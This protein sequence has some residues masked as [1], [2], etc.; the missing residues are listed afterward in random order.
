[1]YSE[2]PK[3][4]AKA[5][6]HLENLF[7]AVKQDK[8]RADECRELLKN[9]EYEGTVYQ[10]MLL[11]KKIILLFFK[12]DTGRSSIGRAQRSQCYLSEAAALCLFHKSF[13]INSLQ[14]FH[15]RAKHTNLTVFLA[16]G[17][18]NGMQIPLD[19]DHASAYD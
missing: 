17:M 18:Q 15:L 19:P 16:N 11:Q 13:N 2:D 8:D 3:Q 10:K 7:M 1:M 14:L 12:L 6:F 9:K 4:H 5:L